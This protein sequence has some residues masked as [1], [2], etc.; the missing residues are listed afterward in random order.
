MQ[1]NKTETTIP[2]EV[3]REKIIDQQTNRKKMAWSALIAGLLYPLLV[4]FTDSDNLSGMAPHFYL[5]V[6]AVV[7]AYI[8]FTSWLKNK[9]D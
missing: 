5:F 9:G 4:L 3:K 1:E 8:G 7:S 2:N 6:G